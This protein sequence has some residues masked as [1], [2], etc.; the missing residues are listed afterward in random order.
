MFPRIEEYPKYCKN[1]KKTFVKFPKPI[2]DTSDAKKHQPT[3][4]QLTFLFIPA[5]YTILFFLEYATVNAA[6]AKTASTS[7]WTINETIAEPELMIFVALTTITNKMLKAIKS[8]HA[9]AESKISNGSSFNNLPTGLLLVSI[10]LLFQD[11]IVSM[12]HLERNL[13]NNI[14]V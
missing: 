3:I 12:L 4:F 6:A 11:K 2:S 9:R 14:L 10:I 7:A 1:S 8:T 13:N 5:P